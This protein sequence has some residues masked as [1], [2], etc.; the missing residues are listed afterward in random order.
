MV[1]PGTFDRGENMI[2]AVIVSGVRTALGSFNGS[3]GG[4]G[5]AKLG[6]IV[7]EEA[8]RRARIDKSTVNG[9]IVGMVLPRGYGQNPAKQAAVLAN[10]PWETECLTG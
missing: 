9:V 5:A 8:V 1:L 2:E 6:A 4:L 10:M 3:L 7:I